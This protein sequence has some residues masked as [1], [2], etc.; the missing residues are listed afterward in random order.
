MDTLKFPLEF[1][2]GRI[3]QI[4][5]GSTEYYKQLLSMTVLIEPGVSPLTPTYG[6]FDPAF[7]DVDKGQF[8]VQAARFVPEIVVDAVEAELLPDGETAVSFSF[9]RRD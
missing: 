7:R 3:R 6:I 1:S 4:K 2:G 5:D 9:K 8:I